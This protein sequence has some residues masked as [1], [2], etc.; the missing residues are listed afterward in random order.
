MYCLVGDSAG[1]APETYAYF[2]FID[3][4]RGVRFVM[5]SNSFHYRRTTPV[6]GDIY[7]SVFISARLSKTNICRLDVAGRT[8]HNDIRR[9]RTVSVLWVTSFLFR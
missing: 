2:D 5:T 9:H 8:K 3:Y 7:N 1:K 4:R 6:Y